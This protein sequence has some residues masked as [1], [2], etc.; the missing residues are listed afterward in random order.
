M[1]QLL[2]ITC[3]WSILLLNA[4]HRVGYPDDPVEP[5]ED[6]SGLITDSTFTNPV[7]TGGPDPWVLQK[8]GTYYYTYTQGSKLVIL[9]TK[10]VSELASSRRY[11]VYT[12]RAGTAY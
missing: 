2:T 7:L 3:L 5:A 1:K 8:N 12:A 4:C 10:N 11:E 9:E 6:L